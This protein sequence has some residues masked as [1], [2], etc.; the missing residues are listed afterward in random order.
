MLEREIRE[1]R[2]LVGGLLVFKGDVVIPGDADGLE[3]SCGVTTDGVF[4]HYGT[5]KF[6]S[7]FIPGGMLC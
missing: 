3:I 2:T 6:T 4:S 5:G 1:A 7:C